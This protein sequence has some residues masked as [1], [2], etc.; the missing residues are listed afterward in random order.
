MSKITSNQVFF[1]GVVFGVLIFSFFNYLSFVNGKIDCADCMNRYGFPFP[2]YE[3]MNKV[4]TL[5][6][7]GSFG[8]GY[9][10]MH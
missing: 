3:Y 1:V 4:D 8:L 7:K 5:Q 6:S 2:L 9:S 10:L